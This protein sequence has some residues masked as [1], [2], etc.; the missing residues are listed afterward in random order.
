[1]MNPVTWFRRRRLNDVS[2]EIR[3]H[4]EEKTDEFVASGMSRAD[5]ELAARRAFGNVV[6]LQETARDVWRFASFIESLATDVRYVLRDLAKKPGFAIAVILT[7]ALGIGANAVVFALVNAVVLRPLPYPNSDR[8]IS[9]S[10]RDPEGR[11]SGVLNEVP[12]ADWSRTSRSV[13]SQAA[14][15]ECQAVIQT[16]AGPQR[17]NY[18]GAAPAYF[19]IFGV[20]PLIGRTFDKSETKPG[21]PQVIVLSEPLWRELFGGD[22]AA[23][24]RTVT[25][26]GR[27]LLVIGV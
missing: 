14:Y 11:D 27:P 12:Y 3:S 23:I 24:G 22:P 4:L 19:G 15:G 17:M 18:V 13:V 26:D 2:D 20:R 25:F 6:K 5:A 10:Q 21:G 16:P 1:M 9:I 7:L 8:I